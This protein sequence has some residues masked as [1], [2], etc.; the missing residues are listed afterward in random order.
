MALPRPTARALAGL[1]A[2][3][4]VAH[5]A[6]PRPFD[7]IVPRALPGSPRTWTRLSGAAEL[8]LAASVAL[9]RTRRVGAL[10]TAG[11]FAAVYPANIKMAR[12][13]R[14]RPAPLKAL[15][16]GRLPLQLPLLAWALY[17]ARQAEGQRSEGW[18]SER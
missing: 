10:A 17:V 2:G 4:G 8:A 14:H 6:A 13:W 16:Y 1:L 11:F 7:A 12:D 15:A 18:R 9:P 5:F 3:A